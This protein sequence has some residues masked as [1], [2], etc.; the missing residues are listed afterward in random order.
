MA[1]THSVLVS[2]AD[3]SVTPY[4]P[5][6]Y[7]ERTEY[8]GFVLKVFTESV[9]VMSD[10]WDTSRSALVWDDANKKPKTIQWIISGKADASP[11]VIETY[12]NYLIDIEFNKRI[13]NLERARFSPDKGDNVKI[14]RGRKSFGHEGPVVAIISTPDRYSYSGRN[15]TK[16]AIPLDDAHEVV[17]L[18]NGG[19]WKKHTNVV[20]VNLDYVVRTEPR[21][22]DYNAIA[23]AAK[24]Y[25]EYQNKDVFGA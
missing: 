8:E 5:A 15:I 13:G 4:V 7:E 23:E 9:Q 12:K 1:I 18:K 14:V 20:W 25:V 10:V 16:V 24:D 2:H 11:E 6:V 21:P 19:T 22:I 17:Q 3:Y